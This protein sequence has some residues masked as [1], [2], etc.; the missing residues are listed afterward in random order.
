MVNN[1]VQRFID[2]VVS[3]LVFNAKNFDT[4]RANFAIDIDN[5]PQKCFE[6]MDKLDSIRN[7]LAKDLELPEHIIKNRIDELYLSSKLD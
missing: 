6:F 5:K 2:S 3:N 7:D 4:I 1:N